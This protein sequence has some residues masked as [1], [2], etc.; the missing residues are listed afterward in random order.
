ML[1]LTWW[2]ASLS[3]LALASGQLAAPPEWVFQHAETPPEG[4][5]WERLGAAYLGRFDWRDTGQARAPVEASRLVIAVRTDPAAAALLEE[6]GLDPEAP[7][8]VSGAPIPSG[9]GWVVMAPDPDGGGRAVLLTAEDAAGL[10]QTLTTS[11]DLLGTGWL[12]VANRQVQQRGPWPPA[13]APAFQLAR[14]LVTRLDRELFRLRRE[15]V[16]FG[17]DETALMAA[18]AF[19]GWRAYFEAALGPGV[20]LFAF[21]RRALAADA[22]QLD[23]AMRDFAAVDLEKLVLEL[24]ECAHE[25]LGPRRGPAPH[26]VFL[27]GQAGGTNARSFGPDAV[28]GRPRVLIDVA[29]H[30][31]P[32]ALEVSLAHELVHTR[33]TRKSDGSLGSQAVMEGVATF[34]TGQLSPGHDTASLLMWS[35]GKLAAATERK[36]EILAAFARVRAE[37]SA[38]SGDWLHLGR[39]LAAVPGAPDR[40]AYWVG[41]LAAQRWADGRKP[42]T[43]EQLLGIDPEELLRELD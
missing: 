32:A 15:L 21:Y 23:R 34:L 13:V 11:V 9:T 10:Y 35:P 24:E 12:T 20:D 43:Y 26:F 4:L 2:R 28:T 25:L 6:L 42:H 18:R 41:Y 38:N 17:S 36:A 19:E 22:A 16:D 39:P 31:D 3:I 30:T 7:L 29:A 1:S 8:E 33:Q 5:T 40:C 27:A 37:P 14:P